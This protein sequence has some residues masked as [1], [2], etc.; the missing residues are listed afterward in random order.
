[1][2]HRRGRIFR[3]ALAWVFAGLAGATLHNARAADCIGLVLGGGGARGA[4]HIGVLKVLERE[5]IPIC[6]VAGTSMGAIVGGMYASGYSPEQIET[7]LGQID[8]KDVLSD[9]P[10]REQLSMRRKNEDLEFLLGALI[11]AAVW[12]NRIRTVRM[13]RAR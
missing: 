2:I 1:M 12:I 4:A 13:E 11:L 5:H 10:P 3:H 8:W 9:D 7:I 6:K